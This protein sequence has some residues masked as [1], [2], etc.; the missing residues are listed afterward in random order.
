MATEA[1]LEALGD[2]DGA[3]ADQQ[4]VDLMT[5]H[6]QGGVHMAEFAATEAENAAVRRMAA[7]LVNSQ[8]A[9]IEELQGRV[10]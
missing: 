2:A 6:H 9:E 10:D 7:S 4:F 1:E 8:T 3:D 5:R